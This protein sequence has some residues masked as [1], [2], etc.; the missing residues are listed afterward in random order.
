MVLTTWPGLLKTFILHSI[1][2]RE[3]GVVLPRVYTCTRYTCTQGLSKPVPMVPVIVV[4]QE[5]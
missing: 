5:G 3:N 4:N 2:Q 1:C